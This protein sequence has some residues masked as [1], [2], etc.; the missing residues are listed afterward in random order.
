MRR[1]FQY[2]KP[3]E[4]GALQ[5]SAPLTDGCSPMLKPNRSIPDAAI[6]PE[7]AYPDVGAAVTW[8]CRAF[9]F[10]E[11][12]RIGDHRA[13]LVLGSGAIVVMDRSREPPHAE[14][15]GHAV[16]VRV[17]GVDAHHARAVA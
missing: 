6:I 1:G 9:G 12:L 17:E 15:G 10:S 8:L 13:Q 2:R 14:P 7:L 4:P 16:L 3:L 11:R 5:N